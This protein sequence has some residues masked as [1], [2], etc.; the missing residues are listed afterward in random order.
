MTAD[1]DAVDVIL[2]THARPHTVGYAIAAVL[3]Q[4]HP[5]L[6]LHVVGDGCD[7]A[8]AAAVGACGD[9]RLRFHRLPK[10]PG[11]G[12]ANRNRVLRQSTAPLVAYA[13]DDDLWFPDHLA[14][15]LAVLRDDRVQLSLGRE[16]AVQ[17]PDRVDPYFFAFDWRLGGAGAFLRHWFTGPGVVVH[18]RTLFDVIGYWNEALLRFGD[19]EFLSRARAKGV[20]CASHGDATLLRFY[21]AVWDA[22]YPQC[23]V[24]PQAR[25]LER[26]ADPRWCA[27]LAE[28]TRPGRRPRAVRRRQLTDFAAFARRSGPKFARFCYERWRSDGNHDA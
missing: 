21:A 28:A 12:Y 7:E 11:Y 26:L 9:P 1:D 23:S 4:T 6:T 14:R 18:R 19:R 15:A 3:R 20:R 22:Q 25:F 2:P 5:R 10:A 17:P 13:S 16:I 8:T 24:P 27:A